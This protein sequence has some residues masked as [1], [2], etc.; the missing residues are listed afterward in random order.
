MTDFWFSVLFFINLILFIITI[1]VFDRV[2]ILIKDIGHNNKS[3]VDE[4]AKWKMKIAKKNRRIAKLA[5]ERNSY[6]DMLEKIN[7][8]SGK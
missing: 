5:N 2:E 1:I 6:K 7:N 8:E 3:F 4:R